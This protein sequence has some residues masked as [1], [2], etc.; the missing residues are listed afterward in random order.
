MAENTNNR[1]KPRQLELFALPLATE[2][3]EI[4]GDDR[5]VLGKYLT[6]WENIAKTDTASR[7]AI[8][9]QEMAALGVPQA[10]MMRISKI[11]G[12]TITPF[13]PGDTFTVK[14]QRRGF[15]MVDNVIIDNYAAKIGVTALAVYMV[16]AKFA[17][18][19]TKKCY[20]SHELIAD[21]LGISRRSVVTAIEKLEKFGLIKIDRQLKDNAGGGK[22]KAAS[23]YTILETEKPTTQPPSHAVVQNLHNGGQC[24]KNDKNQCAKFAHKQYQYKNKTHQQAKQSQ[25]GQNVG[26]GGLDSFSLDKPATS[27]LKGLTSLGISET[28]KTRKLAASLSA[29][30]ILP[31][32][33]LAECSRK[34]SEAKKTGAR[35]PPGATITH[36]ETWQP[37]PPV[38]KQSQ[39]SGTRLVDIDMEY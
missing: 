22:R 11:A 24:A 32:V 20:P 6:Q 1:L 31:N 9:V 23:V 8:F 13:V 10:D 7:P 34:L 15:T 16:L 12:V 14:D 25:N 3:P 29:R 18:A 33:A 5:L 39:P 37:P 38:E 2:R 4:T 17:N 30:G 27:I 36:L 28:P 19:E 26:G 35:N 21:K